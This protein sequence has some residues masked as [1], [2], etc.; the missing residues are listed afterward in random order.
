LTLILLSVCL[1]LVLFCIF[2]SIDVGL[3]LYFTFLIAVL[4]SLLHSIVA[5][6]YDRSVTPVKT[7]TFTWRT[8]RHFRCPVAVSHLIIS[9]L[10]FYKLRLFE[11]TVNF[12]FLR[13]QK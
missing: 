6:A 7:G 4:I 12:A 13:Q 10:I 8:P 2:Y 5:V 1:T 11:V 9:L 3:A